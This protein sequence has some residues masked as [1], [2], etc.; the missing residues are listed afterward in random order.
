MLNEPSTNS[1]TAWCS[2]QNLVWITTLYFVS[3]CWWNMNIVANAHRTPEFT[4]GGSNDAEIATPTNDPIFSPSI[5]MATAAPDGIAMKIPT[6]SEWISHRDNISLVSPSPRL[7]LSSTLNTI[8]P[9]INPTMVVMNMPIS[10]L[11]MPNLVSLGS[12]MTVPNV[13]AMIGP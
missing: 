3:S 13:A 1:S 8:R 11:T 6:T 2:D 12:L 9:K 10:S 5:E 4:A 7:K